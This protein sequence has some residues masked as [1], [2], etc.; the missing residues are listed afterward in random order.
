MIPLSTIASIDTDRWPRSRYHKDLKPVT[1]VQANMAGETDSPIYGMF[2]L[3]SLIDELDNPPQQFF[4]NQ[5]EATGPVA[6]KW[7]GEWQITYETFRDMGLAYSV[8]IFMIFVL[9]VAQ[10]RSYLMPLIIMS[11]IPL[12]LVG[13]LPGHWL[14][15][16]SCQPKAKKWQ[17]N[18]QPVA[19]Q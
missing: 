2:Q 4:I 19:G 9:L 3:V 17:A 14:A 8:G 6:I 13:I 1:Y 16:S 5:P 12:T 18:D 7:D 11:P 10:F 15:T